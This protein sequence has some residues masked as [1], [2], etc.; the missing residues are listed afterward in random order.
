MVFS[1][2]FRGGILEAEGTVEIRF[3]KRDVIKTMHRLDPTCK[4]IKR[5]LA[6][7]ELLKV[8]I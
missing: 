3:R 2:A 8:C 4:E 6:D 7:P 1:L 5:K